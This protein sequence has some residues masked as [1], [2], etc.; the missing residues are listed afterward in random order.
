MPQ[1]STEC[2]D[3]Q[4]VGAGKSE[5]VAL[6]G[7]LNAYLPQNDNGKKSKFNGAKSGQKKNYPVNLII[8]Q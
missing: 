2:S 1:Q 4:L 5:G 3:T 7:G 6:S 8:I